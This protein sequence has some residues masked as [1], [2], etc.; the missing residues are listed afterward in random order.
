MAD[1]KLQSVISTAAYGNA[2][3]EKKIDIKELQFIFSITRFLS[4]VLPFKIGDILSVYIIKD[5]FIKFMLKG[6]IALQYHYTPIFMFKSIFKN[7]YNIPI[8]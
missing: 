7:F 1:K 2:K 4:F 6:N 8:I 5:K 3:Y